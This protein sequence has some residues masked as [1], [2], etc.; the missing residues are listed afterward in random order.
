M[1]ACAFSSQLS[2]IATGTSEGVVETFDIRK[3]E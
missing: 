3:V 2:L 1:R